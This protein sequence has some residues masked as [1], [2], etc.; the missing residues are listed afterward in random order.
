M[1]KRKPA[2]DIEETDRIEGFAHPRENFALLGQDAS[3]ARAAR[4]IRAGRPPQAWLISGPPGIG[5]ATL[6][7]RLARYLLAHGATAEG[8]SDLSVLADN[9]DAVRIAA[10][11][12]PGLLVLKRG[13][14]ESTGKLMT[15]TS[16]NEIRKLAGFF[17]L[18]SGAGGWRV[19]IVDTADDLND[20]AANAL[21]KMLEEPPA[22]A[23]LLLLSNKPGRLL[24]TIRSRCQRLELRI[25]DD[26]AMDKALAQFLP[27]MS[28]PQRTSL[29]QLSGGSLGAALTLATG[30]GEALAA[31]ADR[32]IDQAGQPDLLALLALG[33]RLWR[34]RDGLE[35]FG[36][37]LTEA[38]A[39]RIRAR[40]HHGAAGLER[41][42][43]VLGRLEQGFGRAAALN[44]EPRQTILSAAREMAA[45]ART[46][47]PL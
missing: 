23:M 34:M 15:E 42:V 36:T 28:A 16:V 27:E 35:Q 46:A 43:Q 21:L 2:G 40:A 13:I 9:P 1:A 18:T 14:S 29:M 7:Y 11:A 6:A 22:Q 33:D 4:A 45:T 41:W 37:F 25:L 24:P 38:L 31:E 39:S 32:L 5:K 44:L 26:A 12:H 17:G 3:L 10:G 47:G 19:A 8:L 30:E 20:N